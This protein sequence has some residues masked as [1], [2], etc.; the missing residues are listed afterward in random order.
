MAALLSNFPHK[1]LSYIHV[2]L[3][4]SHFVDGYNDISRTIWE[5]H[6]HFLSTPSLNSPKSFEKICF[7]SFTP[8]TAVKKKVI[9]KLPKSKD[10]GRRGQR[11]QRFRYYSQFGQRSRWAPPNPTLPTRPRLQ[12]WLNAYYHWLWYL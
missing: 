8:T 5:K 1:I 2:C 11:I 12:K 4:H 3:G 9:G 6:T 7:Q 10:L